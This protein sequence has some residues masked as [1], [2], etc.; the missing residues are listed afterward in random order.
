MASVFLVLSHRDFAVM[1][2]NYQFYLHYVYIIS[3]LQA[4]KEYM[5]AALEIATTLFKAPDPPVSYIGRVWF[6]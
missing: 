4:I 2:A 5:K 1:K 3:L 6:K